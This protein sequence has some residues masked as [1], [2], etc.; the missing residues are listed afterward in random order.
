[1]PGWG[2]QSNGEHAIDGWLFAGVVSKTFLYS[3]AINCTGAPISKSFFVSAA[4]FLII[5]MVDEKSVIHPTLLPL[6]KV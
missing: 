2:N 1:V 3:Y 4:Y 5:V 6:K